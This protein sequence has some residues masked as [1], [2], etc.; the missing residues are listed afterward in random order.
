MQKTILLSASCHK[1][2]FALATVQV[3]IFVLWEFVLCAD[4]QAAAASVAQIGF[5]DFG[6]GLYLGGE[7]LRQQHPVV[8][9]V[10]AL[11]DAHYKFKHIFL[12]FKRTECIDIVE[13]VLL[14]DDEVYEL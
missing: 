13:C 7:P 1:I 12:S 14:Q 8:Q 10:D 3:E 9:D 5:D 2:A 11:A 4:R 6:I